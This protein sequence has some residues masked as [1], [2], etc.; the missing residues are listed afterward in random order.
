MLAMLV[1]MAAMDDNI[2]CA[3][4][5]TCGAGGDDDGVEPYDSEDRAG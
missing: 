2:L 5:T 3:L 1:A 4:V